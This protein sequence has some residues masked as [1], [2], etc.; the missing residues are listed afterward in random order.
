MLVDT[1]RNRFSRVARVRVQKIHE[2]SLAPHRH[3]H[4]VGF[5]ATQYIAY[6]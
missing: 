1:G 5:S 6:V 3:G 4:L 2:K